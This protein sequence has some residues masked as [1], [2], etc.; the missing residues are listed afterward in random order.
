MY[1]PAFAR[2]EKLAFPIVDALER[3]FP[4][5]LAK[6]LPLVVKA[7]TVYKTVEQVFDNLPDIEVIPANYVFHADAS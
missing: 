4:H 6:P 3:D 5:I 7:L 1:L 2:L